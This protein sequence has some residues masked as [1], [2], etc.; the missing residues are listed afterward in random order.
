MLPFWTDQYSG[1]PFHP[2]RSR[3]LNRLISCASAA[4]EAINVQKV[5]RREY[6][7]GKEFMFKDSF[8]KWGR[9]LQ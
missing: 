9:W 6:F 1:I 8:V 3:P 2:L 7:I 4:E 5:R